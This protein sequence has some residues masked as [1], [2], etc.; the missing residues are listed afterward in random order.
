M[1]ILIVQFGK[2]RQREVMQVGQD[3]LAWKLE[4]WIFNAAKLI[5]GPL[6]NHKARGK[7]RGRKD[8]L[9]KRDHLSSPP[10]QHTH[11]HAISFRPTQPIYKYETEVPPREVACCLCCLNSLGNPAFLLVPFPFVGHITQGSASHHRLTSLPSV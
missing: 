6:L 7:L 9:E 4:S 8:Y 10:T 1:F 2:P 11:T 5:L 3:Y